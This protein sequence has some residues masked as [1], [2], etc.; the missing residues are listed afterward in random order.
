M[1]ELLISWITGMNEQIAAISTSQAKNLATVVIDTMSFSDKDNTILSAML[2]YIGPIAFILMIIYFLMGFISQYSSGKEPPINVFIR[3]A[4]F[5]IIADIA[6]S[7]S[8]A[9]VTWIGN[10]SV[11]LMQ[12]AYDIMLD[13]ST[14]ATGTLSDDFSGYSVVLLAALW[15]GSLL[16]WIISKI[17]TVTIG[18]TVLSVKIELMLRLALCPIGL[19]GFANEEFKHHSITYLK[20]LVACAFYAMA[21]VCVMFIACNTATSSVTNS[22]GNT[23]ITEILG[24]A[25]TSITVPFACIGALTVAKSMVNE[26]VS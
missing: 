2:G 23:V 8:D 14:N 3:S 10:I 26:V 12:G 15:A 18:I 4:I 19:A 17:A 13:A 21:M 1:R 22:S 16:G 11:N 6:L 9:I 24:V 20:K 7:H 25:L 5:L